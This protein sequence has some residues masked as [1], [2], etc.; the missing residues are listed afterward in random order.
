MTDGG[1]SRII[2]PKKNFIDQLIL[3]IGL[4]LAGAVERELG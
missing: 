3:I 1:L 4:S 2:S